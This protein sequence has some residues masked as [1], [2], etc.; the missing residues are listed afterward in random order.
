MVNFLLDKGADPNARNEGTGW[1]ALHAAAFQEHGKVVRILLDHGSDPENADCDGRTPVDYATISDA[2]W[3]FFAGMYTR[4]L[5]I[6]IQYIV[7]YAHV[8]I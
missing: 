6:F 4:E 3:A 5:R 8:Y 1:T 7:R 2:I